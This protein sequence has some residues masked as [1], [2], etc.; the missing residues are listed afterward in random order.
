MANY[1]KTRIVFNSQIGY[2]I[3]AFPLTAHLW[4]D[5]VDGKDSEGIKTSDGIVYATTYTYEFTYDGGVVNHVRGPLTD[6][7]YDDETREGPEWISFYVK[8]LRNSETVPETVWKIRTNGCSNSEF[9]VPIPDIAE[10]SQAYQAH[11]FFV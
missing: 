2:I 10:G 3:R 7:T 11:W 1:T 6:F 9:K 4:I 5:R 8:L